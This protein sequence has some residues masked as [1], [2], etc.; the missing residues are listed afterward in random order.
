ML[1]SEVRGATN[2]IPRQAFAST[3]MTPA[4]RTGRGEADESLAKFDAIDVVGGGCYG[5]VPGDRL[6]VLES[7]APSR[8]LLF[9]GPRIPDNA[10]RGRILREDL[11]EVV[12]PRLEC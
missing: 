7:C 9:Q 5:A 3:N 10:A 8:C 1:F 11:Q 4:R 6:D 2:M 12:Q